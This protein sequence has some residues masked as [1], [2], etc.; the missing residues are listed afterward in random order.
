MNIK[1]YSI[2]LLLLCLHIHARENF[3]VAPLVSSYLV[4]GFQDDFDVSYR[5]KMSNPRHDN[6]LMKA[7]AQDHYATVEL[8]LKNGKVN[9]DFQNKDGMTA[10]HYAASK[11][12][13]FITRLLLLAGANPDIPD[14]LGNTPLH[15]AANYNAFVAAQVLLDYHA[16]QLENLEGKKPLDYAHNE[17]IR[18]ILLKK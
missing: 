7:I 14:Y 11:T 17:R 12:N 3:D 16:H 9:L 10:L 18:D 8:L 2:G 13:G 6:N 1:K 5:N 4:N 15:V